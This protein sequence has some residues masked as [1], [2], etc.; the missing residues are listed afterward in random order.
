M[1]QVYLIPKMAHVGTVKQSQ[2]PTG[3]K[4]L[5]GLTGR[6]QKGKVY[7]YAYAQGAIG[8]SIPEIMK[9]KCAGSGKQSIYPPAKRKKN[10]WRYSEGTIYERNNIN[11]RAE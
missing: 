6:T 9:S 10:S 5:E 3:M 4:S 7:G 1:Q 2:T 11:E 8:Y